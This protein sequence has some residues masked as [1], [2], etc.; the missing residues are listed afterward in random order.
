MSNPCGYH[1]LFTD[2][3]RFCRNGGGIPVNTLAGCSSS[4]LSCGNSRQN[5]GE[6]CD[7][8]LTTSGCNTDC[9]C[10]AGF[11]DDAA[12]ALCKSVCPTGTSWDDVSKKC[13][14]SLATC[15]HDTDGVVDQSKS[16]L[17][18]WKLQYPSSDS[19]VLAYW[20]DAKNVDLDCF[21]YRSTT[22][23]QQACCSYL[24]IIQSDGKKDTYGQYQFI[25]ILDK[26][27]NCLSN[28]A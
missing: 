1:S 18:K 28:C 8:S 22:K 6:E 15:Y 24:E 23:P 12:T 7:S 4:E 20:N 26:D 3:S 11:V 10:K 13:V 2:F 25:R 14:A 17:A 19:E 27:G 21:N 5:T 16:C 9:T